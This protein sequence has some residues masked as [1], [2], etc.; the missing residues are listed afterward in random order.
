MRDASRDK[1]QTKDADEYGKRKQRGSEGKAAPTHSVLKSNDNPS[2]D[3]IW[4]RNKTRLAGRLIKIENGV[5]TVQ[6]N[7]KDKNLDSG[8]VATV[9]IAPN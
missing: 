4:L 3:V 5:L 7:S 9:L 1:E 6:T 8:Q 2:D